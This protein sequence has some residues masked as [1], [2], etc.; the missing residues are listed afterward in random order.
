MR[1]A[2]REKIEYMAK[3]IV[4]GGMVLAGVF[5][6]LTFV[7][8]MSA[9]AKVVKDQVIK[10]GVF[11][12]EIDLSGMME[13]E[14]VT[15]VNSFL[16]QKMDTEI[17]LIV[18]GG[19]T[20]KVTPEQLGMNWKNQEIVQDALELGSKGNVIQ[21]YKAMKDLEKSNKVYDIALGFDLQSI[22]SILA[23]KCAA[24]DQKAIN[25]SL[26]RENGSF[27]LEE[28]QDGYALD[29]ETS[30][31]RIYDYLTSKWDYNPCSIELDVEV[32][33][34]KNS[35]EDLSQITD[36]LGS[37]T[38]SYRTS[39]TARS[40][41]VS[42]GCRLING[43]LLMPGEE[44]SA[45]NAVKPFS[46]ANGYYMAGSYINGQVV[47]SLGGG[48]CQVSTTLYNA[49]LAAELDVTMRYNHSMI[50]TYVDASADA[51]IAES[52]GKDFKFVNSTDYPIYIEGYTTNDKHIT[53]NIYGKETRDMENRKVKYVSEIVETTQ[54][55]RDNIIADGGQGFGYIVTSGAHVGYK[56]K[57]WK[58]VTE[59][60][61]EVSREEVNSS[62]YK[63]SPRSATVGTVTDNAEAY[64]ALMAAIESGSIDQVQAVIAAYT[65]PVSPEVGDQ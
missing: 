59:N 26:S 15:A 30:L 27:V 1:E 23:D 44:F 36:V 42:N 41:N 19:N 61:V 55:D 37:F 45:Y 64:A 48:I 29:V 6:V 32:V 57:L 51:A 33:K 50:V 28:G 12:E 20:V 4:C 56:A 58:I 46:E 9:Q 8:P 43:T 35:A 18:G 14:A 38:T 31:D 16:Q 22:N 7:N 65:V 34:P 62:N 63:M 17:N 3:R 10:N 52:S 47:D 25:Y 49:V 60:G 24:F 5:A 21:R 40:A 13:E 54:P 2:V 53:F 11:A 39:G